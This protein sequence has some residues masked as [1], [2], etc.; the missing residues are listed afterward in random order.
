MEQNWRYHTS[1]APAPSNKQPEEEH[2][3]KG[4]TDSE[5]I[6]E[7]IGTKPN[8]EQ[9]ETVA[10]MATEKDAMTETAAQKPLAM[11]IVKHEEIIKA[12]NGSFDMD[13]QAK[14]IPVPH[15]HSEN[16]TETDK[17]KEYK[18]NFPSMT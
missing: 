5:I 9:K 10:D 16:K 4:Q 12:K 14:V 3:T 11:T 18:W 7:N 15:R 1:T 8:M 13:T 6:T 2:N 17:L